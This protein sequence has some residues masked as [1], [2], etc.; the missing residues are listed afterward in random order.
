MRKPVVL[1]LIAM[2]V[3]GAVLLWIIPPIPQP[4]WYHDFADK[5]S[6]LGVVNFWN[7]VSNLPFLFVGVWGIWWVLSTDSAVAFND[8]S[9]RWMYLCLFGAV[10]L[11][12]VGSRY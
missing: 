12:G 11:T 1:I 4:Q 8:H 10:A 6:F 2:A 9:E 7:V 3:V 5:R